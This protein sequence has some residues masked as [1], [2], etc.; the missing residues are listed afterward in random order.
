MTFEDRLEPS[1]Y[2]QNFTGRASSKPLVPSFQ[3]Q[4][5]VLGDGDCQEH[6][7]VS[8][9]DPLRGGVFVLFLLDLLTGVGL[10]MD[11]WTTML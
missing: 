4:T 3:A 2:L 11:T 8:I 1:I 10:K 5:W 6:S 9:P 7:G